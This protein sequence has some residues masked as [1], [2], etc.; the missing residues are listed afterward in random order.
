[1][2]DLYTCFD[3]MQGLLDKFTKHSKTLEDHHD[4]MRETSTALEQVT[5][6][7]NHI[8]EIRHGLPIL[9]KLQDKKTEVSI[10]TWEGICDLVESLINAGQKV[11]E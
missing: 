11:C 6:W 10:E 8:K 3:E 1:M 5:G 4:R 9:D 7:K 2:I